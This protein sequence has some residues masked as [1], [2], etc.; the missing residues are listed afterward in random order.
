MMF[1]DVILG[2][3]GAILGAFLRSILSDNLNVKGNKIPWGTLWANVI[4][5]VLAGVL[6]GM[7]ANHAL[8]HMA[9]IFL[10]GGFCGGLTTFSTYSLEHYKMVLANTKGIAWLYWLASVLICIFC[11]YVGRWLYGII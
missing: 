2:G 4:G 5:S 7:A 9:N 1:L 6:V 8:S 11:V 10:I 3:L